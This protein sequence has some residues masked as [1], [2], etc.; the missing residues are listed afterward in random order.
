MPVYPGAHKRLA[1]SL[2]EL[3][4]TIEQVRVQLADAR[5]AAAEIP[6]RVPLGDIVPDAQLLDTETKL[7]THACR[8]AA[9]NTE[10]SLARLLSPHY[11]RAA[12]EARSLLREAFTLPGDL[13]IIQDR[14]HVTLN[15]ASAPRRTRAL[16]ALCTQLNDTE[17]V[18]PGT[19]LILHY[20]VKDTPSL[21]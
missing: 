12:D 16:A 18:Y 19:N 17:T 8:I 2:T 1:D 13:Q 3:A 10:T 7:V 20:A 11:A 15:P 21:A 6:A 4:D 14:L 5:T 9:Y